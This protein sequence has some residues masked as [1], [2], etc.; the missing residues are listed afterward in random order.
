MAENAILRDLADGI[1]VYRQ[2][3]AAGLRPDPELTVSEWA[4][5]NRMV[6]NESSA[7]PGKWS[8]ELAPYLVEVM[9]CLSPSHPCREVTFKKSAQVGGTECGLNFFGMVAHLAPGPMGVF[10]PTV[11]MAKAYNRTK[12]GPTVEASPALRNR[13]LDQKSRDERGSTTMF[14]KFGDGFCL[15]TGANSSSGLQM[16]SLKYVIKEE[17][18]EWP[19]D[20]EGRGDPDG[21]VDKRT[22]GF[23]D[24]RKIFNNSTPGL[25][26]M[27]RV[28]AKYE[29]S[30]K[31]RYYVPCPHCAHEQVLVWDRLEY[32][33]EPPYR[34]EYACVGCGAMIAHHHKREMLAKGRWIAEVPGP[35]REPG[36][37]INQLYSPFVGWDDTVSEWLKAK[38]NPIKE[39]VFSQQVLGE[40]YEEKGDSPEDEKLFVRREKYKLRT[41]APGALFL[42]GAADV[43]SNRLEFA[44]YAW[45]RNLTSWLIDKGVLEGD[46][47]E[48]RVWKMLDDVVDRKY[49]DSWGQMWSVDAFG[50]DSGYLSQ[51]V[52]RF[53]RRHVHK[54][55]VYALDGRAGPKLP[56]L[57]S[58]SKMD[59]DAEGRKIGSVLLWP[60][61]TWDM[62]TELYGALRKLIEGPDS[63][64]RFPV[65]TAHFP[66]AC[67]I[68]YFRQLTAESFRTVESRDGYTI[69]KWV[70]KPGQPN[71]AHDVAVYARAL[72]HHLTDPLREDD[73]ANLMA[74]RMTPPERMQ[75]DFTALWAGAPTVASEEDGEAVSEVSNQTLPTAEGRAEDD[76]HRQDSRHGKWLGERR[77]NWLRR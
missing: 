23:A 41:I 26:G 68:D 4:E 35:G 28:T 52:Y 14:K 60:V 73:W 8:N 47:N 1:L 21:L 70:K 40:D 43:Q 33:E 71:E 56:A 20:V 16:F 67:D 37:H 69:R 22:T 7:R 32:S 55:R 77:S 10:L 30:D 44:V 61:G 76:N 38:G 31:R 58:P 50:V 6:P 65:G 3:F 17:L 53:C 2:S 66:E 45:D 12:L 19:W 5:Q 9:D 51:R 24:E 36:F 54:E 64:G 25:K 62:K 34:A 11:D 63:D 48:D 59:I 49:E 39:K 13:V 75:R 57:G 15:L 18:S 46:P 27:C 42:T 74:R 72:A 29:A